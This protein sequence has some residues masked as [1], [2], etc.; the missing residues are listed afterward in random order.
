VTTRRITATRHG[1]PAARVEEAPRR[2]LEPDVSVDDRLDARQKISAAGLDGRVRELEREA[3]ATLSRLA[4]HVAAQVGPLVR[5]R[6]SI[7]AAA[8]EAAD[9]RLASAPRDVR[10][11]IA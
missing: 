1:A 2:A 7:H 6:D 10:R 3:D 8:N 9:A 4:A 11:V 5:E